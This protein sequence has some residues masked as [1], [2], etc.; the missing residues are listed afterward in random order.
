MTD[1]YFEVAQKL[2]AQLAEARERIAELEASESEAITRAGAII[3]GKLESAERLAVATALLREW[4]RWWCA[5][6]ADA[7]LHATRAFL[8]GPPP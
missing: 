4:D 5:G 7:P 2:E 6:R 1:H 3:G 8:D